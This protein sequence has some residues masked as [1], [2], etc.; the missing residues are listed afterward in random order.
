MFQVPYI[1]CNFTLSSVVE[2]IFLIPTHLSSLFQTVSH[3]S[4]SFSFRH[5]VLSPL[6]SSLVPERLFCRNKADSYKQLLLMYNEY[7]KK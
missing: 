5:L 3:V 4:V 1:I 7:A 6:L 2:L